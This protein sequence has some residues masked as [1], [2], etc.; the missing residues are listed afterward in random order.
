MRDFD[1]IADPEKLLIPEIVQMVGS[2]HEW[3][4]EP[5]AYFTAF[6]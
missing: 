2:I 3:Q 5:F 1:Y 4:N 6:L